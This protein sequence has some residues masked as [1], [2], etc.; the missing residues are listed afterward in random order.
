M[1]SIGVS[2]IKIEDHV[3]PAGMATPTSGSAV[4]PVASSPAASDSAASL[5]AGPATSDKTGDAGALAVAGPLMSAGQIDASALATVRT[6]ASGIVAS[7]GQQDA[8]PR[9]GVPPLDNAT[10]AVPAAAARTM[11]LELSPA[12]LGTVSVRLHVTGHTLDVELS[13]SSQQTLGLVSREQDALAKALRDQSYDLNSL[14]I[15]STTGAAAASQEQYLTNQGG[16]GGGA[17]ADDSSA[18]SGSG[19][20]SGEGQQSS[21]ARRSADREEPGAGDGS[22]GRGGNG[23]F[24]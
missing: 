21:N 11:T 2:N 13:V 1:G 24:V 18:R 7:A 12:H 3:A 17:N 19:S 9:S 14:V 22:G 8:A 16:N 5:L 6:I 4:G 10:G 15:Q 23:L 20:G